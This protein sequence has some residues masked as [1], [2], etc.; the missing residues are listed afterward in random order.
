MRRY[1]E[2]QG[3]FRISSELHHH[4]Q[5]KGTFILLHFHHWTLRLIVKRDMVFILVILMKSCT[6]GICIALPIVSDSCQMCL[7][8]ELRFSVFT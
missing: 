7:E 2:D 5:S 3:S 1:I 8:F 6:K 4:Y